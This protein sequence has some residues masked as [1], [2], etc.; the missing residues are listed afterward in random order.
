VGY[1]TLDIER[2]GSITT[3]TLNRP[4]ARNAIDLDMRRELIIALDEIEADAASRVVIL[5]GRGGHFCAG[6]DVKSMK[7]KRSTAADGRAR[8][9]GLNRMVLKLVDF[10][11]PT[12]AMVE[13]YAVGAGTN[14]ALCC[15]LIVASEGAKFGEL[16]W[17][18]GL[19][20]DGGGT[21]LLPRL[22]GMARAKEL[23]FTAD[24]IDAAEAARIGLVNRVVAAADLAKVTW[25]LAEK[26]AAGPPGVLRLAKNMVNRAAVSDLAAA[27]DLEAYSQGMAL[28]GDDHQEGLNAFFE[29]R[30]PKFTGQ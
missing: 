5:T 19:A 22:V 25:A 11:K 20:P 2:R 30:A 18:I 3:L 29:K 24:I 12:I 1:Q 10:P 8:V 23:I 21:W 16:F 28:A 26:I 7:A 6:G 27:L 13:G 4:E 14:L 15:D 17:K 9:E